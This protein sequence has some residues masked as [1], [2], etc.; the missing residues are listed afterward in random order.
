MLCVLF[1]LLLLVENKLVIYEKGWTREQL[2]K[3]GGI[4]QSPTPFPVFKIANAF[5]LW[6]EGQKINKQCKTPHSEAS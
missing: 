5:G 4:S 6:G 3:R 1:L 2:T